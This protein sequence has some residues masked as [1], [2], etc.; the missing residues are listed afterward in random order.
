MSTDSTPT[1]PPIKPTTSTFK[2]SIASGDLLKNWPANND[3]NSS[4]TSNEFGKKIEIL[5]DNAHSNQEVNI[6]GLKKS[7]SI[8][9]DQ[10]PGRKFTF[11]N[12]TPY[13]RLINEDAKTIFGDEK[14]KFIGTF[15]TENFRLM[16][17]YL[18]STTPLLR[19]YY[20]KLEPYG[21]K[22]A[23]LCIVHGFGEHSGRFMDVYIFLKPK[24]ISFR[25]LNF[26]LIKV[27][28]YI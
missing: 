9:A 24:K 5:P 7:P 12:E 17:G 3:E 27:S 18:N 16:K 19:L 2:S 15:S 13:N 4:D 10:V 25:L 8:L 11:A 26:L 6:K 20:T 14:S 22:L 21:G 1:L 28:W 23:S